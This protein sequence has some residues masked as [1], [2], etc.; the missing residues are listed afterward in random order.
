MWQLAIAIVPAL[1]AGLLLGLLMRRGYSPKFTKLS[2]PFLELQL[3][4]FE[5]LS[6]VE[7]F[8]AVS[9]AYIS[10][11][12]EGIDD[13]AIVVDRTPII[14]VHAGWDI[15][16]EAF[17][18]R[19]Q[20]Y[21]NDDRIDAVAGE[22]GGQNAEFLKMYRQIHAHAIRH[23]HAVTR[24]FAS[25][26]LIRA[27]SLAERIKGSRSVRQDS[28]RRALLANAAKTIRNG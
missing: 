1:M 10:P 27:P 26:Y 14:L 22:I 3:D 11:A 13:A 18:G 19:F 24:E 17:V 15:V 12:F 6:L 8:V 7:M 25:N 9:M 4:R 20:A 21:P 28:F 5:K 2:L 23:S 16:C